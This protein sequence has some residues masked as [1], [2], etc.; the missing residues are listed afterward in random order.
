MIRSIPTVIAYTVSVL[1]V[2]VKVMRM[3]ER[4]KESARKAPPLFKSSHA[5]KTF[6]RF[7][8]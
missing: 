1:M 7:R 3:G 8:S 2:E 4:P 5:V 6:S